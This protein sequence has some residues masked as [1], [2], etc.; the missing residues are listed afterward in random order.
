MG[1]LGIMISAQLFL[2]GDAT[3]AG[4]T[5]TKVY[6]TEL[7]GKY[8]HPASITELAN[9]DLYL[10][11]YGGSGEYDLDTAVWGG[12]LKHGG[13]KWSRPVVIADTPFHSDGNPVVWQAP[14][15]V[16]WLF[17]V[18]RYGDTWSDSR[19]HAKISKDGAQTWSDAFVLGEERGMMVRARPIVLH[20]GDYLL[21][22]YHETGHDREMVGADTTSLFLRCD[23]KTM[24]WSETNRIT[25]R[26][27]CL[28][29][30]AVQLTDDYLV[31]YMRR[32][33]GYEP[34]NDGYLVRAESHDGGRTWTEGKDSAF[35]N[36]N[37]AADFIKLRN[38][39]L[40]LVYNDSM[41]DRSPLTAAISSDNDKTYPHKRNLIVGNDDF[42][43]PYA[44]Q[45]RDGKIHVV[46]TSHE[47]TQVNHAVFD[48]SAIAGP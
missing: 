12:R 40:L 36:P 21:P 45:T 42:A 11:Y 18:V 27:G 2:A 44:I 14:D 19:I 6:G 46:F 33:G 30:A 39:H 24:Q 43:Y 16:V 28:Q 35:S 26:L 20:N 23:P 10:A 47:R 9:E 32:G 25:A 37:A 22:I 41:N 8:K 17:Y 7:P 29:P 38:G 1:C 34:R 4:V 15:G 3:A 13:A 31:A 5:I 48:E